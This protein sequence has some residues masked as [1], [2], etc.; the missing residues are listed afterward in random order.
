VTLEL[1]RTE[2]DRLAV[3]PLPTRRS[4]KLAQSQAIPVVGAPLADET[5][6]TEPADTVV[7]AA[8]AAVETRASLRARRARE[9]LA[10]REASARQATAGETGVDEVAAG[11][12]RAGDM[13]AAST[14]A[15]AAFPVGRPASAPVQPAA[16]R[17]A[18]RV[19]GDRPVG[20]RPT[21]TPR[22]RHAARPAAVLSAPQSTTVQE[23]EAPLHEQTADQ[24]LL[25]QQPVVTRTVAPEATVAGPLVSETVPDEVTVA[26]PV[27]T[28]LEPV[29]ASPVVVPPVAAGATE[30]VSAEPVVTETHHAPVPFP[31]R[32]SVSRRLHGPHRAWIPRT[33]VVA[34][35]AVST[36]ALPTT[37]ALSAIKGTTVK[38]L[39][40]PAGATVA[41]GGA[42]AAGSVGESALGPSTL[43]I[44]TTATDPSASPKILAQSVSSSQRLAE[45]AS[46]SET[47][48][49]LAS[50]AGGAVSGD[51]GKLAES[52]LCELPQGG[53]YLQPD[54]AI[55]F[56]EMSDAFQAK[57]GKPMRVS[58]A[59]RSYGEQASLKSVKGGMAASAGTS[60]HGW[61]YAIDF[62]SS[63]YTSSAEWQWLLDNAAS[64]G[65]YN[66]DWAKTTKYEP[67]HWEFRSGVKSVGGYY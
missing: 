27:V 2:P 38:D 22:R 20:E 55:A 59:Y 21:S 15:S 28:V 16:L 42:D 18:A 29:V 6:G 52:Q 31:H 23:Q 39:V 56:S 4:R 41:K 9:A 13:P 51:N 1:V 48:T 30:P 67:W 37:G 19:V 66:P 7:P 5:T 3:D 61:G 25:P 65:W 47:R 17:G 58:S 50:C 62:T 24:T 49:S 43:A 45:A 34:A 64:F 60:N 63:T 8:P 12:T 33:A 32:V 14:S 26:E 46:R 11:T 35:L 10:A 57:F 36:I 53:Y 40:S 54:A 44:L